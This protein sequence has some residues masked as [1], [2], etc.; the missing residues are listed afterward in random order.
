MKKH[1]EAVQ[2]WGTT[3]LHTDGHFGTELP[4]VRQRIMDTAAAVDTQQGWG[5]LSSAP[6]PPALRCVEVHTVRAGGALPERKHYD[7][8]SLLTVAPLAPLPVLRSSS[9]MHQQQLIGVSARSRACQL[10]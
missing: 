9:S 7:T 8:G 4:W 2:S 5:M 1:G 10:S 3:F 6:A